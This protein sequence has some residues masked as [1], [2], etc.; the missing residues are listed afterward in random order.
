MSRAY[1]LSILAAADL[2][3]I[4]RY[5][6]KQWG[7]QRTR[8]YIEQLEHGA[9]RLALGEGRYKKLSTVHPNLRTTLVGHH[10]VFCLTRTDAP[11]L[12]VAILHE[13]MDIMTR[14]KSRLD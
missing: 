13:R 12:V 7:T 8:A 4:T 9:Q 2:R 6:R 10:Y 5:S 3:E 11:P 1:V 14:L